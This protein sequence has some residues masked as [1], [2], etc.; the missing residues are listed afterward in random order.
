MT[1]TIPTNDAASLAWLKNLATC[2]ADDPGAY[3]TS[4]ADAANFAGLVQEFQDAYDRANTTAT[5]NKETVQLKCQAKADAVQYARLLVAL[6]KPNQGVNDGAKT[7]AGIPLPRVGGGTPIPPPTSAPLVTIY[8]SVKGSMT[9]R[10]RD[11]AEPDRR[12]LGYGV[13]GL[14]LYCVI[15]EGPAAGPSGAE[16]VGGYTRGPIGVPFA[17]ADDGKTAT[18]FACYVNRKLEAGP[19]SA[20]VSMRIAA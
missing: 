18:F 19:M 17:P 20:P 13:A 4:P 11:A 9:L 12:G 6:V 2:L 7:R 10:F 15:A 5:R 1:R 14:N 3:A 8:A 16:P